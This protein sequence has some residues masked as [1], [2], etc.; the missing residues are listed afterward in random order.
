MWEKNHPR[1][2]SKHVHIPDPQE[3]LGVLAEPKEG[4]ALASSVHVSPPKAGGYP[5]GQACTLYAHSF[6]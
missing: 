2:R 6:V 3:K 1:V 4:Q 5:Q